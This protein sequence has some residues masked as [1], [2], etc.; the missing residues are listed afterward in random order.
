VAGVALGADG[1]ALDADGVALGADGVAAGAD[2]VAEFVV[3]VAVPED[4]GV[5][6]E[7]LG[8]TTGVCLVVSFGA[9]LV[10][11]SGFAGC[12]CDFGITV[13]V[14]DAGA[15]DA[16]CV[17]AGASVDVGDAGFNG[18]AGA[19]VAATLIG[20][21]DT[22]FVVSEGKISWSSARKSASTL[23]KRTAGSFANKCIKQRT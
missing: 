8:P 12:V 16:T 2:V 21:V 10:G 17:F 4:C 5:F 19:F 13:G 18:V 11:N 3:G 7:A 14:V 9:D 1:V 23:A 6:V 20:V 15:L 22:G